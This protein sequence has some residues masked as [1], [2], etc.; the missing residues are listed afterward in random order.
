MAGDHRETISVG[1]EAE[2]WFVREESKVGTCKHTARQTKPLKNGT[3]QH[4]ELCH[5]LSV[6]FY[7]DVGFGVA[8]VLFLMSL[9]DWFGYIIDESIRIIDV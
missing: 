4:P 6:I 3:F 9:R 1:S 7:D 5:R 8:C 2:A